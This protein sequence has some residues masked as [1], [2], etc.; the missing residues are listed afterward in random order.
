MKF[1]AAFAV[2]IALTVPSIADELICKEQDAEPRHTPAS[3]EGIKSP[4]VLWVW[5]ADC[6]QVH[7]GARAT[8]VGIR[9]AD[10]LSSPNVGNARFWQC[11][12]PQKDGAAPCRVR[13]CWID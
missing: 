11:Y 6:S 7:E 9:E 12:A 5:Q 3:S 2:L 8:G 1:S 4:N 13:C 10:V